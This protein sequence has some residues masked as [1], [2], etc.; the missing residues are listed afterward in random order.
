MK[1]LFKVAAATLA[2]AAIPLLV[3]KSEAAPRGDSK[4]EYCKM[5]KSQRNPVA[6]NAHYHCLDTSQASAPVAPKPKRQVNKDPYCDMAKSQRNPVSWNE[7]YHCLS[8]R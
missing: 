1:S 7:R 3:V 2:L 6:W 5:A 8:Q 4:S